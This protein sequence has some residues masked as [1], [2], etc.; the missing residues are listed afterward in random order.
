MSVKINVSIEMGNEELGNFL[1]KFLSLFNQSEL[2]FEQNFKSRS[3]SEIKTPVTNNVKEDEPVTQNKVSA[4]V[5][6]NEF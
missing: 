3:E 6:L 2:R 4:F 5:P 1:L